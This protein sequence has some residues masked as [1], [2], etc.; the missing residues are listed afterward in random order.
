M[1][2]S[3]LSR[4]HLVSKRTFLSLSLFV[5]FLLVWVGTAGATA[6][7][8]VAPVLM[9]YNVNSIAGNPWPV[10][11]ATPAAGFGGEG[12][13][14]L[15]PAPGVPGGSLASPYAVAVDSV[16]NVYIADTSNA[17]IREVN[18]LT[19]NITSVAGVIPTGCAGTSCST[20]TSGCADGVPAL[21]HPIGA[22][23][24][25]IAVDS[26]GNIY[27]VDNTSA[28]V[29]VVYRGGA[30]V[31]A[32]ISLENP[33]AA[34]TP[35]AVKSGYVYHVGGTI[36]L[37]TCAGTVGQADNALA[38]QGSQLHGPYELSLDAAANI[39]IL[40]ETN[41]SIRVINTQ[42]VAETFYQYSVPPGYMRAIVNCNGALTAN[43]ATIISTTN[44]G[45]S[46][47]VNN[48]GFAPANSVYFGPGGS[49]QSVGV[50]GYG[51]VFET[52]GSGQTP[53]IYG[54]LAYTGGAPMGSL[55]NLTSSYYPG[56][57]VTAQYGGFYDVLNNISLA[58]SGTTNYTALAGNQNEGIDIRPHAANFGAN[59]EILYQDS[60]KQA[61]FRIDP[62]TQVAVELIDARRNANGIGT[63]PATPAN[64]VYCVYGTTSVGGAFTQGPIETDPFGDG[65]PSI[66]GWI[67]GSGGGYVAADGQGD[68]IYADTTND[69]IRYLFTGSA[70][71]ATSVGGKVTQG[72]QIHFNAK[73]NP[74]IGAPVTSP[75][76]S[77]VTNAFSI[78][79]GISDFTIDTTDKEF[80]MGSLGGSSENNTPTTTNFALVAGLPTCS[81]LGSDFDST[82][83]GDATLDCLVYVTFSPTAPGLRQ[84]AL[85]V[86][87]AN[88]S[89]YSFPLTGI[90][91]GSQLAIDGGQQS[92]LAVNSTAA[93]GAPGEI[94]VDQAGTVY[95]AD[96]ANNRIL[97]Q[98][99][100]GP[101]MASGPATTIGTGLSGPMGV[102]VDAA[103]NV[104]IADTGNNRVLEVN[105]FTGVQTVLGVD[106]WVPGPPNPTTAGVGEV[107]GVGPQYSFKAPRGVAVDTRGNV[108]VADTGNGGGCRDSRR[109]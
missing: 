5:T 9:P 54:G 83:T 71:P 28:T 12:G 25:G 65:C 99:T 53:A 87:T 38:F 96:P 73:N 56:G 80:P 39:Y 23:I 22:K 20:H 55:I 42:P 32:F 2:K 77:Y 92:V 86:T 72:I 79:A 78:S 84:T 6:N 91:N 101:G 10:S 30:N 63:S 18:A 104:Y 43:C 41:D 106:I 40:D 26:Y 33:G 15:W 89:Q 59:G 94:A 14:A 4:K 67:S 58:S 46:S 70:F 100:S 21:N 13:P 88:G 27:F 49:L 44:P 8:G 95:I 57:A 109:S 74:V 81:Y 66:L 11:A 107:G 90:G 29:S 31:A 3:M 34:P 51:N 85:T 47:N 17:V 1:G 60:N 36:N 75:N 16:G 103:D 93:L 52:A 76:P 68:I 98:P 7:N 48:G 61:I 37:A 45:F 19:G 62:W 108:Y 24:E 35:S 64:P 82:Q 50:D 69:L 102:A 105:Q 97:V